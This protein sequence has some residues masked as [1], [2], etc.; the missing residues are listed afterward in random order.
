MRKLLDLS[1]E[2]VKSL[3]KR[4]I[5]ENTNF[6]KLAESILERESKNKVDNVK[7]KKK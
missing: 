3:S 4:A 6:K 5:D 7:K 1:D 2:C